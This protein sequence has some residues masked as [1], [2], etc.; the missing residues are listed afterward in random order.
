M[1]LNMLL[2]FFWVGTP[3]GHAGSV[4]LRDIG[5]YLQVYVA[6]QPGRPTSTLVS[7]CLDIKYCSPAHT[8]AFIFV[9]TQFC[10]QLR[11]QTTHSQVG[12]DI[13][14]PLAAVPD[15]C[16]GLHYVCIGLWELLFSYDVTVHR[17][18]LLLEQSVICV[19]NCHRKCSVIF[20]VLYNYDR[21]QFEMYCVCW[22]DWF[23]HIALQTC[24]N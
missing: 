16:L 9:A 18:M 22:L 12:Y 20:Y 10:L 1:A 3:C 14:M 7:E 2:L 15:T 6:S 13:W 4:L 21:V 8:R 19:R 23:I 5:V 24:F 11:W 17:E